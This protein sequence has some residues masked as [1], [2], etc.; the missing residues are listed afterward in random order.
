MA[1]AKTES[2][3]AAGGAAAAYA[4]SA[5]AAAAAASGTPREDALAAE[6][7]KSGQKSHFFQFPRHS[8]D[9]FE[10]TLAH[11]GDGHQRDRLERDP[12]ETA[13]PTME[14]IRAA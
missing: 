7:A 5:A 10:I 13:K 11:R 6:P 9:W 8:Y 1:Q 12:A 4:A 2:K 3:P 14:V